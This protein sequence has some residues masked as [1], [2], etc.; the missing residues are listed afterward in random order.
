MVVVRLLKT[1]RLKFTINLDPLY[2][3]A[4]V[5]KSFKVLPRIFSTEFGPIYFLQSVLKI[6]RFFLGGGSSS[7][8]DIRRHARGGVKLDYQ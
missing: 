7:F 4:C 8:L 1:N 2:G 5:A 3:D 6:T